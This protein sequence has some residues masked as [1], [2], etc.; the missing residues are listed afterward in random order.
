MTTL[1]ERIMEF[2]RSQP[3]VMQ[4]RDESTG[5]Y[6]GGVVHEIIACHAGGADWEVE[7]TRRPA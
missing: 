4:V 1:A 3:D 2:L 6:G 7:V 5:G